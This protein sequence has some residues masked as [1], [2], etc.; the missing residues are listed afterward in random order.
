MLEEDTLPEGARSQTLHR[1]TF[2]CS[3]FSLKP[4]LTSLCIIL[5]Y[6]GHGVFPTPVGGIEEVHLSSSRCQS[7]GCGS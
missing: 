6:H 4:W 3:A 2:S 1:S 5:F 7:A